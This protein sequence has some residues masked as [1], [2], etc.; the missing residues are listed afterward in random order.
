MTSHGAVRPLP[1]IDRSLVLVE[2][3]TYVAPRWSWEVERIVEADLDALPPGMSPL[4][5]RWIVAFRR[6]E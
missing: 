5:R 1:E 6:L 4:F 3:V 2:T